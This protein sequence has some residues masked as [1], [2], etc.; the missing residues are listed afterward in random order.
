[1]IKFTWSDCFDDT[2][3]EPSPEC[4]TR[5][6]SLRLLLVSKNELVGAQHMLVSA[7]YEL[8]TVNQEYNSVEEMRVS[9]CGTC[10]D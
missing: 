10:L 1:M 2:V 9:V 6:G 7:Q 3:S 5:R 4:T 8:N